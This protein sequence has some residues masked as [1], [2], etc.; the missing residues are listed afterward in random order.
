MLT[1]QQAR[2]VACRAAIAPALAAGLLLVAGCSHPGAGSPGSGS[3]GSA[4]AGGGVTPP[5]A[6]ASPART[7]GP[8]TEGAAAFCSFLAGVNNAA[9]HASSQQQGIQLLASIV[10]TLQAQRS[11][12]PAT[13]ADDFD[14]VLAAAQQAV[15]Q[16]N[17]SALATNPVAAAG[18]R[19]SSYCHAR[20]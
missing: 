7:K 12:V 11:G 17:L 18:A 20:S 5:A 2:A 10:P 19:L 3:A 4:A 16:G 14:V 15:R 13:A 9:A 8:V 6:A 1:W